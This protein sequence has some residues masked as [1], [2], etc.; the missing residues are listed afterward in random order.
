MNS[1][2]MFPETLGRPVSS[3]ANAP[4]NA[5]GKTT[6]S[7]GSQTSFAEILNDKLQP[8]LRFSNHAQQRLKSRNIQLSASD[9]AKLEAAVEKAREKGARESLILF[10]RLALVVSVKNSTVITAVDGESMKEN[11]F[12]NID[13]AAIV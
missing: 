8:P 1:R 5:P 7:P 3:P 12:T 13:S 9:M 10:D 2:I 11:V 4:A 6:G